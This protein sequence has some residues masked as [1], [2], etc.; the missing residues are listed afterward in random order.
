MLKLM[1][2]LPPDILGVEATGKVTHEDYRNVLI[3]AAEAKMNHGPVK[4]LYVAGSEFSGY[5]LLRLA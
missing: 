1:E 5:E 2:G 3:P 4:M